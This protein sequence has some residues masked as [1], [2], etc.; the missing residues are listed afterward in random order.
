MKYSLILA[1]TLIVS[2]AFTQQNVWTKKSDF[3]AGKRTRAVAFAI[4]DYGYVGTGEDTAEVIHNDLWRYEPLTDTWTQQATMPGS[5]RRNGSAIAI[6]GKGYVG[7]GA[8]SSISTNGSIL[9]D[10]WQYDPV[11]N[12]W[13]QK[14]SYP[15]G[16]DIFN[17]TSGGGV[18]FATAFT[19]DNLGYVCCGKMGPDFY[20][21]DLWKY[22]PSS[23]TWTRLADF[24]GQDRYQLVSCSIDGKGYVGMGTDH[25]LYRKDWWE[26]NPTS[27]TWLQ[28]ANLPG[29][30]RGGASGFTLGQHGFIV[31]G[32]DGGYKDELWEY[33]PFSNVWSIRANSPGGERKDAIAFVVNGKAYAGTGKGSNGKKDNFYEYAPLQPVGINE[34]DFSLKT[35]PNPTTQFVQIE[36]AAITDDMYFSMLDLSGKTLIENQELNSITQLDLVNF[37]SGTYILLISNA[38]GEVLMNQKIS[39]I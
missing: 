1:L 33:N 3:G 14:A 12:S 19:I 36:V 21:T 16:Y 15:G 6:D 26:Y 20:G 22:D 35:F 25:D 27:D 13:L 39:K 10:W 17:N 8:D 24:P 28:K 7:L 38:N 29:V 37:M 30:V 11:A 2:T 32:S 18:C 4:G 34:I 31:Y 23:D 9:A 5:V